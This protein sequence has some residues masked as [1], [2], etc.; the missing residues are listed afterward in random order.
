MTT[1]SLEQSIA[2]ALAY[3]D[4]FDFPLTPTE[5][6]RYLIGGAAPLRAVQAALETASA[7]GGW[8]QSEGGYYTLSGR[9]ALAKTRA[10]RSL[11]AANLWREATKYGRRISRLPFVRMVAVTGALAVDN[12]GENEDIDYL[13]VTAP[14]RLWICRGLILIL[15]RWAARGGVTLCPNYLI[16][17]TERAM[18]F[19]EQNLYTAHEVAQMVPLAGMEVYDELRLRNR[20]VLD[21]L[22]NANGA[23][24]RHGA[25]VGRRPGDRALRWLLELGLPTRGGD[26]LEAWE[27]ERK[28]RKLA[29]EKGPSSEAS[30]SAEWCKGH[31][32]HHERQTMEAFA[33]RLAALGAARPGD[34]SKVRSWVEGARTVS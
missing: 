33:A 16:A 8:I 4:V 1:T 6:H 5:I 9:R 12:P 25:P 2:Q 19:P 11:R 23:P 10:S 22:P 18:V 7:P 27:M 3:A 29:R 34:D 32:H 17:R 28:I 13:I 14:G 15:A 30:F 31:F 26:R 21:Y 24:G 20:W